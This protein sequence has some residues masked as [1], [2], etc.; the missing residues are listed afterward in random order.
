MLGGTVIDN[1]TGEQCAVFICGVSQYYYG[2]YGIN[3]TASSANAD[4][5]KM[6]NGQLLSLGNA[7]SSA[8]S[9]YRGSTTIISDAITGEYHTLFG[10][11]FYKGFINYACA[12]ITLNDGIFSETPT[13]INN[14]GGALATLIHHTSGIQY[15]LCYGGVTYS[16]GIIYY[17]TSGSIIMI[18]NGNVNVTTFDLGIGYNSGYAT[19]STITDEITDE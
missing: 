5:Y 17:D 8:L 4:V 15:A 13:S 12:D 19:A 3:N 1:K 10:C 2:I 18:S 9:V 6:Q 16:D 14:G 11:G 7:L